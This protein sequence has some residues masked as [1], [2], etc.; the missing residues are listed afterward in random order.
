MLR[1][2]RIGLGSGIAVVLAIVFIG[3]LPGEHAENVR[4]V[5]PPASSIGTCL[6]AGLPAAVPPLITNVANVRQQRHRGHHRPRVRR[7]AQS[8][9]QAS[10]SYIGSGTVNLQSGGILTIGAGASPT[11]AAPM[12]STSTAEP[13]KP[14]S[15]FTSTILNPAYPNYVAVKVVDGTNSTIDPNSYAITFNGG[16]TGCTAVS[17]VL[18]PAHSRSVPLLLLPAL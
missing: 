6:V 14:T 15:N 13:C 5:L 10:G 18:L 11:R 3:A 2:R 8:S 9:R 17:R 7:Y 16:F 1:N 4:L 12:P